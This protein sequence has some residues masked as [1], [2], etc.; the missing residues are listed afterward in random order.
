MASSSSQAARVLPKLKVVGATLRCAS[1]EVAALHRRHCGRS[2]G[3][4]STHGQLQQSDL[5]QTGDYPTVLMFDSLGAL[6]RSYYFNETR[7]YSRT[8]VPTTSALRAALIQTLDGVNGVRTG[9]DRYY[10]LANNCTTYIAWILASSGL[11]QLPNPFI[12][13]QAALHLRRSFLTAWPEIQALS[14]TDL[15]RFSV[16]TDSLSS[17]STMDLQ[18]MIVL[19]ALKWLTKR[20]RLSPN[21]K[22]EKI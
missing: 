8:I 10:F 7:G 6:I 3:I 15:K 13:T 18:R 5:G 9:T 1:W 12:P 22:R 11:A 21:C 16:G 19:P 17:V 14:P 2:D 4:H 20:L